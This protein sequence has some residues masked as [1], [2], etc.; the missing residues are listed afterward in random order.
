MANAFLHQNSRH[1]ISRHLRDA[2]IEHEMAI[3]KLTEYILAAIY[4]FPIYQQGVPS[5][6]ALHNHYMAGNGKIATLKS[7]KDIHGSKCFC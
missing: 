5:V 4:V 2:L 7:H 6:T 1:L 3:T